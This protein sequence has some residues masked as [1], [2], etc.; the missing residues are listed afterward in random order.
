MP[1]NSL[2]RLPLTASVRV[3]RLLISSKKLL[4]PPG[5]E[6]HICSWSNPASSN[7]CTACSAVAWSVKT[8]TIVERRFVAMRFSPSAGYIFE[9]PA[10]SLQ[11]NA[12]YHLEVRVYGTV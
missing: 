4:A 6:Y 8:P 5:L 1:V 12:E 3:N 9:V 10:A 7:A 2:T 11:Q